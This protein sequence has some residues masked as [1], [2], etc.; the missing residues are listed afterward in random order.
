MGSFQNVT[1]LGLCQA[2]I[3]CG[4]D[5]TMIPDSLLSLLSPG[6]P[7]PPNKILEIRAVV[8]SNFP[9]MPLCRRRAVRISSRSQT[10]SREQRRP[11]P[12][13]AYSTN[14]RPS[15]PHH[16]RNAADQRGTAATQARRQPDRSSVVACC[17]RACGVPGAPAFASAAR[18]RS[19]PSSV[20]RLS[21][22]PLSRSPRP[23]SLRLHFLPTTPK[24]TRVNQPNPRK[25]SAPVP[26]PSPPPRSLAARRPKP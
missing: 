5:P 12:I 3:S 1:W 26:N 22:R 14:A 23:V 11:H 17:V 21:L 18:P 7:T 19:P 13:H 20:A 4:L 8:Q 9:T 2:H 6:R 15:H 24:R 25:L 16:T 10:R